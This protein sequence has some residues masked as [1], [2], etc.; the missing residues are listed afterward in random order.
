MKYLSE[1]FAPYDSFLEANILLISMSSI[2]N[3][4]FDFV[5]IA[6]VDFLV[7][8]IHALSTHSYTW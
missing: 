2:L 6:F 3:S 4:F 1:F 7:F 5:K 8:R